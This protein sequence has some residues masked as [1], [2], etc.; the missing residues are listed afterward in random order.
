M[1]DN[2]LLSEFQLSYLAN[3]HAVFVN[4]DPETRMNRV[5][6]R[7]AAKGRE[8][9]KAAIEK[10]FAS[11]SSATEK[12]K[13]LGEV[14]EKENNG[15]ITEVDNSKNA[16]IDARRIFFGMLRNIDISGE[17]RAG[18]IFEL[19]GI[20]EFEKEQCVAVI[21][22]K[23]EEEHRRYHTWEHIIE[24]LNFLFEHAAETNMSDDELATLGGAI[25][26]HDSIY[27]IDP[28]YYRDNEVRSANLAKEFLEKYHVRKHFVDAI[29]GLI[30]STAHG[31]RVKIENDPLALLLHDSDLAVLGSIQ[32]RYKLYVSDIMDEL[33]ITANKDFQE[34]RVKL[35]TGFRKDKNL[36]RTEAGK[37]RFAENAKKN[38][39]AEI[40][41]LKKQ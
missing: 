19:L 16:S 4:A 39:S 24:M 31:N 36:Y 40:R 30:Y 27:S 28:V 38:L 18:I 41:A 23:H 33:G 15:S 8:M 25:L 11:Q 2:A 9:T 21:K 3:H 6:A 32:K 12:K 29:Y 22:K 10:M 14:A 1:T 34:K 13:T 37:E 26:F 20:S 5:K 35:L 17:L 7:Y